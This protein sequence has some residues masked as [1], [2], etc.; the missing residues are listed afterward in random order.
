[1]ELAK[2]N[3]TKRPE[4]KNKIFGVRVTDQEHA[5]FEMLAW[6][7]GKTLSEWARE[8]LLERSPTPPDQSIHHEL[9]TEMVGLQMLLMGLLA[10][11]LQG[12][13]LS[14]DQYQEIVRAAQSG[15]GKR[16]RELLA[17]RLGQE[18]K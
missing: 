16:A 9:F 4:A 13:Q 11:L 10:P 14:P 15:K 2:T 5:D 12:R 1:M 6:A 8:T 18:E 17:Q 3:A 7:S